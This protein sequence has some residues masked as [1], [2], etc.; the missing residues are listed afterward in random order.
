MG[1]LLVQLQYPSNLHNPHVHTV[2]TIPGHC[3]PVV[4]TA[5]PRIPLLLQCGTPPRPVRRA[6]VRKFPSMLR[7]I[8]SGHCLVFIGAGFCMPAGGPSWGNLLTQIAQKSVDCAKR[9]L[10][11][12]G[13]AG[14]APAVEL[15]RKLEERRAVRNEVVKLVSNGSNHTNYELAA[16]LLEDSLKDASMQQYLAEILKKQVPR[17]R[18]I[19][20][21]RT[22]RDKPSMGHLEARSKVCK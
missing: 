16:Q 15:A 11:E 19:L 9:D 4:I 2:H 8:A 1:P 21:T 7:E 17:G 12:S 14:A 10:Q 18:Q 20:D 6:Q 3:S 5:L 22:A 13:A